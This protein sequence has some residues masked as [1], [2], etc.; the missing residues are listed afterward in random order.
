M[1]A[2]DGWCG[3]LVVD[4]CKEHRAPKGGTPSPRVLHKCFILKPLQGLCFDTLSQVF[5]LKVLAMQEMNIIAQFF[6]N[7]HSKGVASRAAIPQEK[8][9]ITR[10]TPLISRDGGRDGLPSANHTFT[11]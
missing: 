3:K 1:R 2:R 10:F 6:A 11:Y 4:K 8:T 9:P 5:I 7:V